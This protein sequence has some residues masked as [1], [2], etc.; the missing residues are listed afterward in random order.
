[1]LSR[2]RSPALTR[3]VTVMHPIT[4]RARST[5]KP[6][7]IVPTL[8]QPGF[9]YPAIEGTAEPTPPAAELEGDGGKDGEM[10]S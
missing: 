2:E 7:E 3:S 9:P 1:M 10:K 4:R 6:H 5:G 8:P